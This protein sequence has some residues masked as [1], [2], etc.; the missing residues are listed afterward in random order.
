[1]HGK[2][3]L[4]LR[5]HQNVLSLLDTVEEGS[6]PDIKFHKC[7]RSMFTLKRDLEK[8]RSQEK[9]NV[10]QNNQTSERSSK[11]SSSSSSNMLPLECTFCKKTK[12]W[13]LKC[14]KNWAVVRA[15][16]QFCADDIIRKASEKRNDIKMIG[17]EELIA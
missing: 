12:Y 6:Y 4:K 16:Q 14:I 13:K 15:C 9:N 3:L 2:I 17:S 1:M 5:K 10:K 7:C 8:I 11:R